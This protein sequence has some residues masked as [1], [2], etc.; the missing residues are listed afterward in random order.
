LERVDRAAPFVVDTDDLHVREVLD[1]DG[2]ALPFAIAERSDEWLGSPLEITL[3]DDTERV[4]IVYQ[5]SPT[6]EAMQWLSPEQTDGKEHP[7]LFTQGQAILTRSWIPL[8]DSPAVRVTWNARITAPRPLRT[9]MSADYRSR[10]GD[11]TTFRMTRPVPSY[12]IALACGDL[13]AR[14]VSGRCAVWAEPG[15]VDRATE[16]LDDLERMVGACEELFGPY[17]WG[18]YD[19]L[20]LPPSFPFGGMEN[21]CMTFATPTI[22]AGDKSLVALIAHELAHSWSGNLVTNATWRDF[23]LNEGF[24]VYLEQRIMEHVYG[25]DRAAMEIAL[26]MQGL[27]KELLDLPA[28]DQRLHIDLT[29]RNPDDGMT[30]VAYDKGAAFLR[31]LEQVY[32]RARMDRFLRAWF[33]EHAF[34]SVTTATFL[35]F[36]D[37]RLLATDRALA[38]QVDVDRWVQ[39]QGLPDDAPI[40]TSERFAAVDA[41]IAT[42]RGGAAPEQLATDGWVTQ[43]WLRFLG[44]LHQPSVEQLAALDEAFGFTRSGNSEIL[45]AWLALATRRGYHAVDARLELFLKTVGRRKFLV[46]L[47]RAILDSEGGRERALRIYTVA[48]PRY[49]AVSQ[50]TLDELLGW[51][52]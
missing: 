25:E 20:F 47:Y 4:K 44:G 1:Q 9:V 46:P 45:S 21:P 15:I 19:V 31:R 37:E 22:L 16:E 48:R 36:L 6:A 26:G 18:R 52:G 39:G 14:P 51:Q 29:G 17:R 23:W 3:A 28:E 35:R 11:T 32:G 43:Q 2:E 7:F 33:D 40:P 34:R 24:T 49:H 12:L 27:Q 50:R 42:L 41:A 10:R 5:T 13:A 8:Q 30:A 38:Q